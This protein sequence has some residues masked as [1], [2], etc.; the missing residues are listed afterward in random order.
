MQQICSVNGLRA[1]FMFR[2]SFIPAL[3]QSCDWQEKFYIHK[4]P[5]NSALFSCTTTPLWPH[6][7]PSVTRLTSTYTRCLPLPPHCP[8]RTLCWPMET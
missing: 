3:A 7:H 2:S 6:P 1:A 8:K 5:I 4:A